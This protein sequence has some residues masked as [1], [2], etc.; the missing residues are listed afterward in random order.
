MAVAGFSVRQRV[1]LIHEVEGVPAATEGTVIGFYARE[2]QTIVVRFG[3]ETIV[4]EPDAIEPLDTT[5]PAA[6]PGAA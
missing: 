6:P 2:H 5:P 3:D 4:V 1:R